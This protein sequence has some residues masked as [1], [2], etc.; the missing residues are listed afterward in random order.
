MADVVAYSTQP[1]L[2]AIKLAWWRDRLQELDAGR[3]PAEPRL[4]AAAKELLPRGV[5]G[6]GLA[7]LEEGWAALLDESPDISRARERGAILFGLAATLLKGEGKFD[8]GEVGRLF[9]G[10]EGCPTRHP[11]GFRSIGCAE[12]QGSAAAE[13]SD[14]AG[15]LGCSRPAPW[16]PTFRTGGDARSGLDLAPPSVDRAFLTPVDTKRFVADMNRCRIS[17]A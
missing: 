16:R 17:S 1:A 11:R 6:I 2:G 5:S 12:R 8:T 9:A 7:R 14:R 3:V 10:V 4:K 13:A 15:G